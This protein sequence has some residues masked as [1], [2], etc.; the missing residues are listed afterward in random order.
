MPARP[1]SASAEAGLSDTVLILFDCL[2][3]WK[4][5]DQRPQAASPLSARPL[6]GRALEIGLRKV[7]K[8][9][10]ARLLGAP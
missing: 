5:G 7:K 9:S 8:D 10:T 6:E 3:M 1:Q 2:N 4:P